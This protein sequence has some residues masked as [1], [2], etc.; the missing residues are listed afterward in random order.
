[1]WQKKSQI[2]FPN[3]TDRF[4]AVLVRK[5]SGTHTKKSQVLE[6]RCWLFWLNLQ[7]QGEQAISQF[8]WKFKDKIA[9]QGCKEEYFKYGPAARTL[10]WANYIL[11]ELHLTHLSSPMSSRTDSRSDDPW[12]FPKTET[13]Q[14][15]YWTFCQKAV[16][17]ETENLILFF[18]WFGVFYLL[19]GGRR[20]HGAK[21][22]VRLA[23]ISPNV[24]G[25]K[26]E[27]SLFFWFF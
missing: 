8:S 19:V 23:E 2:S 13:F 14:F 7:P 6:S 25:K 20:W 11:R 26:H 9:L 21:S 16:W 1:M 17:E 12:F 27:W 3:W 22:C 15:W 18:R 4:V 5:V 10:C 24:F